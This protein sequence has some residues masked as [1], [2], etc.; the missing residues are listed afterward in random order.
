M[1]R[2]DGPGF[3]DI[4]DFW[5][6][7]W[8]RILPLY[9]ILYF[10]YLIIYN[11]FLY[12][13][14][15]NPAYLFFLQNLQT[16]PRFFGESWSLSIEEW[17][18]FFVPLITYGFYVVIR[19]TRKT[20]KPNTAFLGTSIGL[21]L[22]MIVLRYFSDVNE[23]NYQGVLYRM[24]AIA[25]G[26]IAAYF[27]Y[28]LTQFDNFKSV[29]V[30]LAGLLFS[31]IAAVI[32]MHPK[33]AGPIKLL[34]FP[35]IGIGTALFVLGM[36]QYKFSLQIP[37]IGYISVISYSIYLIH[38]SGIYVPLSR[39]T[40]NMNQ[41]A[42]WAI[43]LLSVPVTILVSSFTYKYI[44]LP[45]LRLRKRSMSGHDINHNQK[46][47]EV[48]CREESFFQRR[49]KNTSNQNDSGNNQ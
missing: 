23:S 38:L 46:Y 35:F 40:E 37:I 45:F 21:I 41:F 42:I 34:Y 36:Y 6:R 22:T 49:E 24:D 48:K 32:E 43:W 4:T 2:K 3:A 12:P 25:Y 5:I 10:A 30:I 11:L 18:Y 39:F 44:E 47:C 26:L 31:L 27:S 19:L 17:F 8:L 29:F 33:L 14:K 28:K 9:F 20:Q 13:V 7:R 1:F 16:A 15:F